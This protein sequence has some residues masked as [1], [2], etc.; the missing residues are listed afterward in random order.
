MV[1]FVTVSF[2]TTY[3][4]VVPGK[5]PGT[6]LR[7]CL[8]GMEDPQDVSSKCRRWDED[9][10]Y[11]IVAVMTVVLGMVVGAQNDTLVWLWVHRTH[12]MSLVDGIW[13]RACAGVCPARSVPFA[14]P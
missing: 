8:T 13:T 12:E 14:T 4:E 7:S 6:S 9:G 11:I 1:F 5:R 2:V 3:A 10:G